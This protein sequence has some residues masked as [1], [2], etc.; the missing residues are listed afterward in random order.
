MRDSE[1]HTTPHDAR[2]QRLKARSPEI[3]RAFGSLFQGLMKDGALSAKHK[4]L[5]A[6]GIGVAVHCEPCVDAHVAKCLKLGATEEEIMEATG[7][8]V[9]MGGGPGYVYAGVA[10]AALDRESG[11][12]PSDRPA[13]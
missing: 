2:M 9:V 6:L 13:P 7:V 3:G 8:G 11:R 5:I 10:A 12:A 1:T 4:E